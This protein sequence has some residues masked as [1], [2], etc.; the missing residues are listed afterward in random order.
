MLEPQTLILIQ[1]VIFIAALIQALFGFGSAIFAMATLVMVIGARQAAPLVGLVGIV[2]S[3]VIAITNR[4]NIDWKATWRIL[5]AS[6]IGAPFGILLLMYASEQVIRGILGWTLILY[7]IYCFLPWQGVHLKNDNWAFPFGFLGGI[8]GSAYN[9][10]GPPVLIYGT[11]R[12]WPAAEFRASLNGYF[13]PSGLIVIFGHASAGLWTREVW[14]N[15]LIGLP[16]IALALWL[17]ARIT[18]RMD[19]KLFTK[20]LYGLIIVMGL[21]LLLT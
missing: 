18:K 12:R 21:M 3:T 14:T 10:N 15:F 5:L 2:L 8:L 20:I 6:T 9:V 7:G 19:Q 1:I 17:G 11:L 4:R 16:S 13:V